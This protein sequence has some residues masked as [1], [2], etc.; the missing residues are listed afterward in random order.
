MAHRPENSLESFALAE[1]VGVDEIELD[2]RQTKDGA[3]IILHDATFDRVAADERGR[4]LPPVSELTVDEARAVPL[5]SGAPVPTLDEVYRATTSQLQVEIK[6]PAC[7]DGVA[8][9]LEQQPEFAARTRFTSF[10][11]APLEALKTLLPEVPRGIIVSGYP[12]AEKHP[13]GIPDL[14]SRT[15]SDIFHCGWDG[16]TREIVDDL[17]AAGLQVR[18]WLMREFSDMERAIE[19]GIDGTTSDD[20]AQARSW[21]RQLTTNASV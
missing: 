7:V 21:H 2:V 13:A 19:L 9:L 16:L 14:L 17:H 5:V 6:D 4:G 20:P 11:A 15:G 18:A 1:E 3:L 8:A 10:Q 12:S